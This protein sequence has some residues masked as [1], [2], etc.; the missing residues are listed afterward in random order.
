MF[1]SIFNPVKLLLLQITV[2]KHLKNMQE[3]ILT[4]NSKKCQKNIEIFYFL[5]LLTSQLPDLNPWPLD[6]ESETLPLYHE[7]FLIYIF[8]F[9]TFIKNIYTAKHEAVKFQSKKCH[10]TFKKQSSYSLWSCNNMKCFCFNFLTNL[11]L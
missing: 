5:F 4:K 2:K 8:K 3:N 11:F 9:V 7:V 1:F 6:W 10:V